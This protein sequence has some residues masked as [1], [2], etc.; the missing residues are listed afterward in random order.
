MGYLSDLERDKIKE[1]LEL[2]LAKQKVEFEDAFFYLNT[3]KMSEEEYTALETDVKDTELLIQK[4]EREKQ[5]SHL[6]KN[7]LIPTV[8]LGVVD[9]DG[10]FEFEAV[11]LKPVLG[12]CKEPL[13]DRVTGEEL[14][15]LHHDCYF[16]AL[17]YAIS[18]GLELL[19][20]KTLN[21]TLN[22]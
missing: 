19:E 1:G 22:D 12:G 6:I 8:E 10:R 16:K 2:L 3:D 21:T 20:K 18:R 4:T 11:I 13:T 14:E 15:E 17:D 9:W 7:G 5:I